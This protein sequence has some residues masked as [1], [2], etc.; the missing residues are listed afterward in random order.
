MTEDHINWPSAT[1]KGFMEAH[2]GDGIVMQRPHAARGTVQPQ[3]SP[4]LTTQTGGGEWS[5]RFGGCFNE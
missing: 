3:Q 4:T 2:E 5:C 1:Q